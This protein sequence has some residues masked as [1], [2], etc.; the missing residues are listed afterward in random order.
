MLLI[1]VIVSLA[2]SPYNK[3]F[4]FARFFIEKLDKMCIAINMADLV[5]MYIFIYIVSV[6]NYCGSGK[7][8]ALTRVRP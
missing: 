7:T 2:I 4:N 6:A 5:Y 3:I 8:L 1:I